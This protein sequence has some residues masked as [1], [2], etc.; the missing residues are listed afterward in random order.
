MDKGETRGVGSLFPS[1]LQCTC[2]GTESL[3]TSVGETRSCRGTVSKLAK[4]SRDMIRLLLSLPKAKEKRFE[5]VGLGQV[6]SL[7]HEKRVNKKPT[8]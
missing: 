8:E 5:G 3:R 7:T 1:A 2:L 6:G 4:S